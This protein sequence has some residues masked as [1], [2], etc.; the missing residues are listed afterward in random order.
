MPAQHGR[1]PDR[2]SPK[3]ATPRNAQRFWASSGF[4]ASS[5]VAS[6]GLGTKLSAA[7]FMQ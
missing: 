5:E 6:A 1:R 7:E 3:R 4:L 2:E